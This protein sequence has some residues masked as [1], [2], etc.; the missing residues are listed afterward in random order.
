MEEQRIQKVAVIGTGLIGASWASFFL[1]KGLDVAA[2]D[3]ARQAEATLRS[4]VD[5]AWPVLTEIG[6]APG[7]SRERLTFSGDLAEAV[8]GVDFVQESGPELE[9][10]KI[11]IFAALD[12]NLPAGTILAS[13][14]SGLRM[15]AIQSAC[16]NP[17]R[18]VIGHPL[19]PPH[20]MPLVEIVGGEKTS[21]ET[22]ERTKRF[23]SSLGKRTI[24]VRKEIN[25]FVTNRLQAALWREIFYLL[26]EGVAGIAEVDDAVCWGLGLRWGLMGPGL[27]AHLGGG[28]GGIHH[29]I[30]YLFEPLTTWWAKVDPVLTTELKKRIEEEVIRV[31]GRRSIEELEHARDTGLLKLLEIRARDERQLSTNG[32]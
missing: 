20:L 27:L 18:C 17:A 32:S 9:D 16:K 30:E 4:F 22:I 11:K 31:A 25:G 5:K 15:S 8:R 24:H 12:A 7:A 26:S 21:H 23:Y 1:S 29:F 2:T 13:S 10:F 6:L 19:N 14:S 3:V 28:S